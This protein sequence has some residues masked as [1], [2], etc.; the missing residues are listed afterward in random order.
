MKPDHLYSITPHPHKSGCLICPGEKGGSWLVLQ[1]IITLLPDNLK[2]MLVERAAGFF[3]RSHIKF[4][5]IWRYSGLGGKFNCKS[6]AWE[7]GLG[8]TFRPSHYMNLKH[9]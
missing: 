5:G 2:A 8:W 1:R 3:F 7:R 4:K 6:G 9:A